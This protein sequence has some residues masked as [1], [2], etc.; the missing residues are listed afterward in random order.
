MSDANKILIN[1]SSIPSEAKDY[2]VRLP[3]RSI[4]PRKKGIT[5][6]NDVGIPMAELYG[7]LEDFHPFLD[8]AKFGIGSAFITTKLREKIKIYR[9]YGVDVYFGGTLFEKFYA[10]N[11][12]LD[13]LGFLEDYDINIIEVSNGTI[14]TSLTDRMKFIDSVSGRFTV[15]A[16]VGSKDPDKIMPPSVWID[17]IQALLNA[18]C[19][20]VILEGRDSAT[21]GLYR[22][23]GELRTGL[24]SDILASFDH[25][26]LIFEAPT[27][28][29]QIQFIRLLGANVNLGNISPRDILLLEAQRRG[30][31]SDTFFC[32][33]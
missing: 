33:A 20:Y 6:I 29:T 24:L 8:I 26:Q 22:P 3:A 25:K 7:L 21:A 15:I 11:R 28:R 2:G 1:C 18:G 14:D 10:E 23:S 27:S 5:A 13:Y 19:K 31:R 17:E 4:K 32:S 9:S 16:E 30:L 12:I